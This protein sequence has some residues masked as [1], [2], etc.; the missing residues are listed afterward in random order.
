M[1]DNELR[2]LIEAIPGDDGWWHSDG[3]DVFVVL[4]EQLI[5]R[6]IPQ[7]EALAFLASAYAAVANEYGN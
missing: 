1:T 6:G 5:T 3:A 4:A 2:T 7:G